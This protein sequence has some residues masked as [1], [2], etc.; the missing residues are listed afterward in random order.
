MN[1][2]GK[3]VGAVAIAALLAAACS[4]GSS[5][6]ETHDVK[7]KL[8]EY[9]ISPDL[10]A[11]SAGK[12]TFQVTNAGKEKH[13]FVVLRTNKPAGHLPMQEGEASEAGNVGEIGNL[14]PGQT[15]GLTLEL[16][17]GRYALICNLPGHYVGGMH[18][19]FTVK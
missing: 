18:A 12:V 8:T 15:K 16:S 1:R 11:S 10:P 5:S 4:G 2:M 3:R 17:A 6:S 9:A 19:A 7:V 13:E 14:D